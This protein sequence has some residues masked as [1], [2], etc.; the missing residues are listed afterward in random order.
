[1][2]SRRTMELWWC[3]L[4]SVNDP[5]PN[6]RFFSARISTKGPPEADSGE[7]MDQSVLF[8]KWQ[9]TSI[10]FFHQK[11]VDHLFIEVFGIKSFGKQGFKKAVMGT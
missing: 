7:E 9:K 1:M 10:I 6:D 11:V 8:I 2:V 5:L 3:R 4:R